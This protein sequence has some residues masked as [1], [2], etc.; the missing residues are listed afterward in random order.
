[1]LG[2]GEIALQSNKLKLANNL[3]T[4]Y[5]RLNTV[6]ASAAWLGYRISKQAG[7]SAQEEHY[8]SLLRTEFTKTPEYKLYQAAG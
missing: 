3:L 1:M 2:L 5:E 8:A 7:V 4:Q 6:D